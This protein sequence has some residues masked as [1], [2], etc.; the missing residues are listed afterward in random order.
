M[1]LDECLYKW[2]SWILLSLT[3]ENLESLFVLEIV[4]LFRNICYG[5]S[6]EDSY[7]CCRNCIRIRWFETNLLSIV[8]EYDCVLIHCICMTFGRRNEM[9]SM[10]GRRKGMDSIKFSWFV[11]PGWKSWKPHVYTWVLILADKIS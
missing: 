10:F 4:Y 11:C 5:L 6:V 9:Y 1:K 7:D 3:Y 8:I 2:W